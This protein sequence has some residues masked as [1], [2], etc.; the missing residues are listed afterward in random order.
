MTVVLTALVYRHASVH[1]GS[2]LATISKMY[3]YENT[4]LH[5]GPSQHLQMSRTRET[6]LP[7]LWA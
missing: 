1:A 7:S 5:L 2:L 3:L 6:E 4:R